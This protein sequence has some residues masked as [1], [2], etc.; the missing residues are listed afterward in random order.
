MKRACRLRYPNFRDIRL[1]ARARHSHHKNH[2][3]Y[4][5]CTLYKNI[6][7]W[8][9][10][11]ILNAR[12]LLI[13]LTLIVASLLGQESTVSTMDPLTCLSLAS[14]I[15]QFVDFGTKLISESREIYQSTRGLTKENNEL[16]NITADLSQLTSNLYPY[17]LAKK[18]DKTP[19]PE[20]LAL[21]DI[22]KTCKEVADELL[23]VLEDLKVKGEHEKWESFKQAFRTVVRREKIEG[24]KSRLEGVQRQ[25]Q[26]R[27]IAL[28]KYVNASAV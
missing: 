27:L 4:A 11:F 2:H 23:A 10:H 16:E 22:A 19:S 24:L 21:H 9:L 14:A 26:L 7:L 1:T 8:I 25:L 12:A 20:E 15:V 17:T 28:L 18:V 3:H 6:R 13:Y 5:R